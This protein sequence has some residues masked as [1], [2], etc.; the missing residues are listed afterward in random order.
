M[1][2]LPFKS[3]TGVA[4]ANVQELP[5]LH[6]SSS[7][8]GNVPTI[9]S[10]ISPNILDICYPSKILKS[11]EEV[12]CPPKKI[13]ISTLVFVSACLHYYN[14]IPQGDFKNKWIFSQF[15]RIKVQDQSAS[16][17]GCLMRPLSLGCRQL[18]SQCPQVAFPLLCVGRNLWCLS[19]FC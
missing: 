4:P 5:V 8:M 2:I 7:I 6:H 10:E 15:W 14:K 11:V 16:T 3:S 9:S 19:L 1:Y 18:P 17:V 13:F 12:G